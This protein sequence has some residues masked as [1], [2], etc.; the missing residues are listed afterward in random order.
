M[1]CDSDT[2]VKGNVAAYIGVA[3]DLPFEGNYK[4]IK[5]AIVDAVA[6]DP[7]LQDV[8]FDDFPLIHRNSLC[9]ALLR[10][11]E[12]F[13]STQRAARAATLL[14]K[15]G[16]KKKILADRVYGKTY[17]EKASLSLIAPRLFACTCVL[18]WCVCSEH[19]HVRHVLYTLPK[20]SSGGVCCAPPARTPRLL[21]IIE[22]QQ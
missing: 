1:A 19:Q 17:R 10:V 14:Q 9:L 11:A 15:I 16:K 22:T 7:A 21:Y 6:N 18:W 13:P 3:T 5:K 2:T 8:P 12:D 20:H 4:A